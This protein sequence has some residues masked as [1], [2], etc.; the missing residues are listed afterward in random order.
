MLG[1]AQWALR[2]V[3]GII[4]RGSLREHLVSFYKHTALAVLLSWIVIIR[5]SYWLEASFASISVSGM[6][7]SAFLVLGCTDW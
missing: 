6:A 2:V 3:R 4:S 7:E 5:A 1:R